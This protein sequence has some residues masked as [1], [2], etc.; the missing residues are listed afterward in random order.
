MNYIKKTLKE[1]HASYFAQPE[2]T[3]YVYFS[4][5]D[6]TGLG[7]GLCEMPAGS[8]N[9]NHVHEN[10]DEVIHIVSGT[11]KFVFPDSEVILNPLD[12]IF[13][14]HGLWHQI[15]NVGAETAY[16]TFTFSDTKATDLVINYYNK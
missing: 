10:A 12:C 7:A 15:F 11:F 13:I 6:R 8:S 4:S 16:H 5:E 9:E 14:P 1:A 3:A 2:R